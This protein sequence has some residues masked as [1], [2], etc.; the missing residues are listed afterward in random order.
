MPA[1]VFVW[2]IVAVGLAVE[3]EAHYFP[4][5]AHDIDPVAFNS[6]RR[7]NTHS[8]PI[9]IAGVCKLG[10]DEL[11]AKAPVLLVQT[12]QHASV[13]LVPRVARAVVVCANQDFAARHHR[14]REG[15]CA[16]GTTH[17]M[18]FPVAG[19]KV[20]GSPVSPDTI[21]REYLWPHCG[22]SSAETDEMTT[23]PQNKAQINPVVLGTPS[24][25]TDQS[26]LLS[27]NIA[28]LSSPP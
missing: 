12:Q 15:L 11:P 24:G 4:A 13:S 2:S 25:E 18:F 9:H 3:V 10:N 7:T 20:S 5:I 27:L 14:G 1:F 26:V 22:W 6:S 8:G 16:S 28:L 23:T 17:L 19:S 21:F